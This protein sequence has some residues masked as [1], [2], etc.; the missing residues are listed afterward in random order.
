MANAD[1][2]E[3]VLGIEDRGQVTGIPHPPR[4]VEFLQRAPFELS[5]VRPS[6]PV[7][8]TEARTDEGLL[9]LHFQV[10]W[11]P[12]AHQLADGRYLRRLNDQN[13]RFRPKRSRWR[14]LPAVRRLSS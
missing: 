4:V 13:A 3:L 5:Y 10:D 11:S 14:S 8:I 1:G 2:G 6:L 9:V 12:E 7:R